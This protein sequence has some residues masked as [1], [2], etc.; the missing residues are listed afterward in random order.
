M[1][2]KILKWVPGEHN[3]LQHTGSLLNFTLL[4]STENLNSNQC[5]STWTNQYLTYTKDYHVLCEAAKSRFILG[6][7]PSMEFLIS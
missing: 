5:P 1:C 6:G 2:C 3:T 7:R 4:I